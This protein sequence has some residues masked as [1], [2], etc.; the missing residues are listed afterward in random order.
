MEIL[1]VFTEI[2][3][4]VNMT[5]RC[6]KVGYRRGALT[7]YHATNGRPA[8]WGPAPQQ[9]HE[10]LASV[11]V[12]TFAGRPNDVARE[13]IKLQGDGLGGIDGGH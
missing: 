3:A 5:I 2:F 4:G 10:R 12:G 1:G 13:Y 8:Q 7:H 6:V 11:N 9:P